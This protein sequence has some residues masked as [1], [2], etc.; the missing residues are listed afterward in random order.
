MMPSRFWQASLSQLEL[1][2]QQHRPSEPLVYIPAWEGLWSRALP[3]SPDAWVGSLAL[4]LSSYTT[5][6][7]LLISLCLSFLI[8]KIIPTLH[9][10]SMWINVYKA[11]RT[12]LAYTKCCFVIIIIC[13]GC[14]H[15]WLKATMV[16][17]IHKIVI[18]LKNHSLGFF[19]FVCLFFAF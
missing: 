8:R 17:Y 12:R 4:L 15:F 5:L 18:T 7:K 19:L 9:C 11:P 16:D 1:D 13:N 14:T 10:E 6:A 3:R 2:P